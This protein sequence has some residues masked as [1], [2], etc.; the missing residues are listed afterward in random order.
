MP[1][2]FLFV[3]ELSILGCYMGGRRELDEVLT[4]VGQG[5]LKPVVDTVFPLTAAAQA[6][7]PTTSD[8]QLERQQKR[9]IVLPKPSPD[10]VRAEADRAVTEYAATQGPGR[11]VRDTSPVRPSARPDLDYDVKNAIQTRGV[12]DALRK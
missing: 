1:L 12:K 7:A 4:L 11:I 2:R 9:S 5:L 6:P 10:Q 8:L 3:K